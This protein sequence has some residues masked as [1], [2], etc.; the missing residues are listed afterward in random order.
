MAESNNLRVSLSQ[1]TDFATPAS[2]LN[3]LTLL[4]TGQ[5]M[6]DQVGY[7][8]SQ[9]IRT[10]ANV[11]DLVRLSL[12]ANGG[13]PLEMQ[14]P[15]VNEALWL[16]LRAALRATEVAE[17]SFS[18]CSITAGQSTINKT[19]IHTTV[20]VGD[21]VR[22]SGA[23][24]A[25]DNGFKR[26]LSKTTDQITVDATWGSS[27]SAITV[28]R[29]A[30][31]VNGTSKY[32]YDVEVSHK[33]Q[34]PT[35]ELHQFFRQAAVDTMAVTVSDQAIT[36][37]AFG[38]VG[39]SSSRGTSENGASY[40]NP[41]SSPILDALGVPVFRS[42]VTDYSAK[43]FGFTISNNIRQRTQ[44]ATLGATA[45]P[46]GAFTVNTR[47]TSYLANFVDLDAYVGNTAQSIWW[48]MQNVNNQALSFSF[49][50][51]KWADLAAPTQGLNQDDYLE[52]AGQAILHP[53]QGC[54]M[55]VQRWAS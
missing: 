4:T 34:A 51:H 3:M 17:A 42:G 49:P 27:S 30:R 9:T 11:Q 10:D 32:F 19:G 14:F 6:R 44:V 18:S 50:Q 29:G 5:T 41:T 2:P 26:V 7:V 1:R 15:V 54:T 20:D 28:V 45:L 23:S 52:G 16:L 13:I 22:L 21:I 12:A 47:V 46:F 37:C 25:A 40:A 39:V 55:R 24:L 36:S 31:M 48:V 33:E 38:L 43:S 8:Q 53:T 35:P